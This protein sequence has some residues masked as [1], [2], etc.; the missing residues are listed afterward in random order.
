[1]P[2]GAVIDVAT[3]KI[4]AAAADDAGSQIR[5]DSEKLLDVVIANGKAVRVGD[6]FGVGVKK[7]MARRPS[8][9][10]VPSGEIARK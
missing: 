9:R 7:Q 3:K 8:A 2:P 1:M 6:R 5:L 4:V 10:Y